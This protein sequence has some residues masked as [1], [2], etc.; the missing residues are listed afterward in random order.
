MVFL[1]SILGVFTSSMPESSIFSLV[2][3]DDSER[4][5]NKPFYIFIHPTALKRGIF[6][7]NIMK[8]VLTKT[9]FLL[10][11]FSTSAITTFFMLKLVKV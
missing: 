11:K 10:T 7:S 8:N 2:Y 5:G 1:V 3:N 9:K 6:L 4:E